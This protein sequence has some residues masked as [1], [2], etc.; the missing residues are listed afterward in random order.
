VAADEAVGGLPARMGARR[1]QSS[2][3][4]PWVKTWLDAWPVFRQLTGSDPL[5]RGVAARSKATEQVVSRTATADRVVKSVCPYCAVGCGQRVFVKDEKIVQIEG[6]PDSP[7]S[8]GRLCPKGSASK[9]LVTSPTRVTTVKYRR[10]YATDWEDLDLDTAMEMIA[11]RVLAARKKGWQ[12][13]EGGQRV[14]RTMGIAS[15]GG[16][17]LDNEEN[18]LMKKL[19]SALGAI[20]IEN[21]ARI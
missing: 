19:Y 12:D 5:G 14:N 9:Q 17:T 10:P 6:D 13:E 2:G 15:L 11:D 7:I 1:G 4:L 3:K 21:Q 16:A 18:Y 20:Q 8:R